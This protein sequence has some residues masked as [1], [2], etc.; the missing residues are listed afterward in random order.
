MTVVAG[1]AST[2]SITYFFEG[3]VSVVDDGG[4]AA[5]PNGYTLGDSIGRSMTFDLGLNGYSINPSPGGTVTQSDTASADY[6]YAETTPGHMFG[7][8]LSDYREYQFGFSQMDGTSGYLV[9]LDGATER[10]NYIQTIENV[11]LWEV[12][13]GLQFAR[14]RGRTGLVSKAQ[15]NHDMSRILTSSMDGTAKVWDFKG[16]ELFTF[17]GDVSILGASWSPDGQRVLTWSEENTAQ[18]WESVSTEELTAYGAE[19]SLLAE[20]LELWW[21]DRQPQAWHTP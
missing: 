13:Q 10:R 19:D 14:L 7:D 17:G 9:A 1:A 18:L 8:A 5:H 2:T 3:T 16:A 4:N 15:F 11:E 12:E 21:R 20:Q 6:F